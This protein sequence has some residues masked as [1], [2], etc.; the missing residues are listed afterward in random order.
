MAPSSLLYQLFIFMRQMLFYKE[1]VQFSLHKP[2][3]SQITLLKQLPTLHQKTLIERCIALLHPTPE[4][5]FPGPILAAM[6]LGKPII[7]TD[8]GFSG[9]VLVNRISALLIEP[10]PFRFAVAM[11]RLIENHSLRQFMGNMARG[12]FQDNFCFDAFSR[13]LDG[14]VAELVEEDSEG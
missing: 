4:D 14:M 9:E 5:P 10:E 12:E 11:H 13:Q 1:L 8:S 3:A 6:R 2:Y 7:S